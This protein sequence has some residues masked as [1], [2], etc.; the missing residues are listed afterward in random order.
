M[1]IRILLILGIIAT[2]SFQGTPPTFALSCSISLFSESYEK[3][4]LLLHGKLVEKNI[5][6]VWEN[7][8]LTS[9][10]FDTINVYK[11]EISETFT[12]KANLTWDDYYVEGEEYVLFADEDENGYYRDDCVPNYLSSPSIIKFLDEYSAKNI[13]I[14]DVTSL[15]DVVQGFERDRLDLKL[16]QYANQ[17]REETQ[18]SGYV[19]ETSEYAITWFGVLQVLII[20]VIVG[21]LTFMIYRKVRK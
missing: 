20:M 8:K 7:Q 13:P 15:Y 5:L 14:S 9:L 4:D 1:R 11:G 16:N 3:H 10:T 18:N 21:I 17:N 2:A 12:V 19:V 6:P